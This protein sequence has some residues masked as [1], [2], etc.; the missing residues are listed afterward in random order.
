MHR[1]DNPNVKKTQSDKKV[2][3]KHIQNL[4]PTLN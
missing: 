3:F 1:A 2:I 4:L